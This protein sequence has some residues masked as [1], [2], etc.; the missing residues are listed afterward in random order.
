MYFEKGDIVLTKSQSWFGKAIRW[1]SK[2]IGESKTRV[3]HVGVMVSSED[4]VESL[5]KTR[6][7]KVTA[8]Y[9]RPTEIAVYRWK[10]LTDEE[11]NTIAAKA[12][13]YVG[14]KYGWIKI[15]AHGLDRFLNGAYVFRRLTRSERYPIC[16][17][18]VAH[19]YEAAG[20][21]FG[22]DA[23]AA[24]PDDIWDFI[25]DNK[26]LFEEIHPLGVMYNM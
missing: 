15:I 16:S 12:E 19:S 17:W 13:S 10:N 26:G 3:N 4:I 6:K 21:S 23:N 8:Y 22:T 11:I 20:L 7:R 25:Q 1:F 14:A 2:T 5:D 18:V 24:D 9:N